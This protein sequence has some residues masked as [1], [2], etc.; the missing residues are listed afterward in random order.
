MLV[1]SLEK[2]GQTRSYERGKAAFYSRACVSCHMVGGKGG[3]VGPALTKLAEKQQPGEIL[4]SILYPSEKI[5]PEYA[6]AEIEHLESGKVFAGVL[7]PQDDPDTIFLVEDPLSECEPVVFRRNE[8][9][10]VPLKVSPMPS[11]LLRRSSPTEVLDLVAYLI[12][13]GDSEHAIFSGS[14]DADH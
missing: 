2:T 1:E 14:K 3:R 8:V 12:S 10:I 6:K 7:I 5:D 4:R 9:D 11:D 13:G